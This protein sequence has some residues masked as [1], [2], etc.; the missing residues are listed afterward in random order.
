MSHSVSPHSR[1]CFSF[2]NQGFMH[3]PGRDDVL[4]PAVN[5]WMGPDVVTQC[6]QVRGAFSLR[7][8]FNV[9]CNE[10]Q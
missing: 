8:S 1:L 2:Q 10:S 9:A 3:V 4:A 7:V 5:L 6:R